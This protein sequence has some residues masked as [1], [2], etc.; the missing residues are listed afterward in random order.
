M[1]QVII[2]SVFCL[3]AAI[4]CFAQFSGGNGTQTNPYLISSKADMQQL[5]VNVNRGQAYAGVYF[6]LT[7]NLTEAADTLTL[8]VG[9]S[10]ARYFS[11]IFD[12]N[13]YKIAV[14][15]TGI[16][17]GIQGATIKNLEVS[18]RITF[19]SH[20]TPSTSSPYYTGGICGHAISSSI[21]NCRNNAKIE[22]SVPYSTSSVSLYPNHYTGGI[23]GHAT[24]SSIISNCYNTNLVSGATNN[25]SLSAPSIYI[26]SSYSGGICGIANSQTTINN[27]YNTG[28][29][30]ASSQRLG[31]EGVASNAGGI[32]GDCYGATIQNCFTADCKITN[33]P[34]VAREQIGRIGNREGF[35]F[36]YSN[37]YASE[38]T[39][40]NSAPISSSNADSKDGKDATTSN[41]QNQAWLSSNLSWDFD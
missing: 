21:I 20:Y 9:N 17:G 22:T 41:L 7:R 15:K 29:V 19:F 12:G 32:C 11:G 33:G 16:F 14:N 28:Y 27:C 37:C 1:K 6:R 24:N 38:N 3:F 39:I 35:G 30:K 36:Y 10:Y 18:G 34:D 23:C 40:L 25:V 2:T 5:A 31:F 13:G 4:S 8:V 26:G